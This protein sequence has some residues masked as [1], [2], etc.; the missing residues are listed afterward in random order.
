MSSSIKYAS[1]LTFSVSVPG[2]GRKAL[3]R[4]LAGVFSAER[5]TLVF[6]AF[7]RVQGFQLLGVFGAFV[8]GQCLAL[9]NTKQANPW[10]G[11]AQTRC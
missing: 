8:V 6:E 1:S 11:P 7:G 5:G 10:R 4:I 9:E 2:G 3:R